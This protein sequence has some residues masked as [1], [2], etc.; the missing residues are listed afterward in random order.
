MPNSKLNKA[1]VYKWYRYKPPDDWFKMASHA[2]SFRWGT[3]LRVVAFEAFSYYLNYTNAKDR[4]MLLNKPTVGSVWEGICCG[5]PLP[6]SV[7]NATRLH[8]VTSDVVF[9]SKLC[10]T[11]SIKKRAINVSLAL[12]S[13]QNYELMMPNALRCARPYTLG[14]FIVYLNRSLNRSMILTITEIR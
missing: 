8:S 13:S 4:N 3:P 1:Q 5:L 6:Y 12:G 7:R 9:N 11:W 14:I 10:Y 2:H